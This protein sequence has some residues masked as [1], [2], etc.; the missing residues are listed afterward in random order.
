M[1]MFERTDAQLEKN[2]SKI[3]EEFRS[4]REDFI[5]SLSS[6]AA[7]AAAEIKEE[8]SMEEKSV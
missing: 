5:S 1:I 2:S 7:V 6:S 3:Q 8:L 4:I